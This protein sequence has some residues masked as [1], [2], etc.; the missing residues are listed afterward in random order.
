MPDRLLHQG[1]WMVRAPGHP[2]AHKGGKF[3]GYAFEHRK[4]CYDNLNRPGKSA[5]HWCDYVLPWK[6][7]RDDSVE[8]GQAWKYEVQVDHL[9]GK[10][11]KNVPNNLKPSC[12]WCNR[13]RALY[14]T[15]EKKDKDPVLLSFKQM[16][17]TQYRGI[18]PA[19]RP[20]E[21]EIRDAWQAYWAMSVK[22]ANARQS[23]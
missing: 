18:H 19:L 17:V 21:V 22:D 3:P 9:D 14:P 23:G 15:F 4:V 1:Y 7:E 6:L 12:W 13:F 20:T 11:H 10:K 2:M 5:C 16:M 8:R